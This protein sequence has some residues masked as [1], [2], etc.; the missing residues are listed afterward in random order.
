MQGRS[1]SQFL[2]NAAESIAGPSG[3]PPA[4]NTGTP[5]APTALTLHALTHQSCEYFESMLVSMHE[6]K[7]RGTGVSCSAKA[8]VAIHTCTHSNMRAHQHTHN[9]TRT[10][11][12][13]SKQTD[14]PS[15]FSSVVVPDYT[16]VA[17]F[18]ERRMSMH[19]SLY[20]HTTPKL[21]SSRPTRTAQSPNASPQPY[22]IAPRRARPQVVQVLLPHALDASLKR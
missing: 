9:L 17:I 15:C 4:G 5:Q 3:L 1:A 22:P 2:G 13:T 7:W 14:S 19:V 6:D 11:G 21:H 16:L 12:R 18:H 8:Q 20:A 10:H